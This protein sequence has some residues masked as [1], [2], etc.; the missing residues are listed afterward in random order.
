MLVW[1]DTAE[2]AN[3]KMIGFY[4]DTG[5]GRFRSI[6]DN[7]TIRADN[8]LAMDFGT[9]F[10]GLGM[11]APDSRLHIWNGTAGAIAAPADTILTLENDGSAYITILAP[12]AAALFFG[13][14]ASAT[15]GGIDYA[16]ATDK[17]RLFAG[18]VYNVDVTATSVVINEPG[19]D[20]DTRIESPNSTHMVFIDGGNDRVVM[21]RTTASY[22]N[23]PALT[24]GTTLVVASDSPDHPPAISIIGANNGNSVLYFGDTDSEIIGS[25]IY[26]HGTSMKFTVEGANILTL[27]AI[28]GSLANDLV[29]PKTSGKGIKVDTAAATFGYRDLQGDVTIKTAGANDPDFSNY[30]STGIYRYKFKNVAMTQLF[31]DY[32]I[33]HDY[34]PGTDIYIHIHWSQTTVDS[35]AAGSP[36]NAKWYFDANYAKGHDRGAFPAS[37]VTVSLVQ[38][39][40]GTI[41]KH[42]I[43]EVQLSTGGQIGGQ[44]LE[45]DGL[46][47]VRTY[48]DAA[49]V[50]DTLDERSWVHHVDIHYQSTNI[51]TKAK[52]P[53]FYT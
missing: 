9:G 53:P 10:I 26:D 31:N 49:D 6:N 4:A 36:G 50:A 15:I 1:C 23:L 30:A 48:R 52:A 27:T 18:G 47:T 29:L 8:I 39:A 38:T 13:D 21:A 28:A 17:M 20:I 16:H 42:L 5:I 33:P 46:A 35:G 40:S 43:G 24:P 37:V 12:T 34:V 22:T 45:P 44:D 25:I 7:A 32:H 11:A 2:A 14:V 51:A 41:R 3:N 19:A